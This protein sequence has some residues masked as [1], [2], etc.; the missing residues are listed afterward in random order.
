VADNF[1]VAKFVKMSVEFVGGEVEVVVKESA[2]VGGA[3]G[4]LGDDLYAI[5]GGD[6]EGFFNTRVG[7][8]IAAGVGQAGLGY[9]E[10]LADFERGAHVIHADELISHEAVNLWIVEK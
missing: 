5:A 10:A 4:G 8:E 2:E 6:D 1:F 9:G 3:V 7:S